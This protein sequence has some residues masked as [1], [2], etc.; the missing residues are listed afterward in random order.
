MTESRFYV[1]MIVLFIALLLWR[2]LFAGETFFW[3]TPL[4]QFVPWLRQMAS[5]WRAGHMPLWNQLVGCGAPLAANYQAAVFY[6]PHL[7]YLILP[8]EVA[9]VWLAAFHLLLAGWGMYRWGRAAGLSPFSSS[10]GALAI[11]GSGFLVS[12]V[13]LFPSIVHTFPWLP[14]WLWCAEE[15]LQHSGKRE[16]LRMGLALGMGLLAGHAQTAFYGGVLLLAYLLFRVMR[17]EGKGRAILAFALAVLLGVGL[18]AV[19]LLPT[20]ELMLLSQ[21][22]GGVRY[23]LAM[24]YSFW[25]WRLI[26]FFAPD[27]F[28]NPGRGD[29]WGYA[30]Y[31]EDAGYV[32]LLPLLLALWAVVRGS[33][34]RS[35]STFWASVAL[36][37]LT[38]ALGKNTPLFP[39][40]FRYLPTF[41]WFQAPARW[42]AVVTVALAALAALGAE[43]WPA[44]RQGR[45]FGAWAI[46]AGLAML[47]GG[48]AARLVVPGMPATFGPAVIRLGATLVAAGALLLSRRDRAWWRGAVLG[49]TVLDLLLAGRPL[50]PTVERSLYHAGSGI[51]ALLSRERGP[52]RIYWPVD[53]ANPGSD[54]DAEYRVRFGYLAF[55][56]FGPRDATY[57]G[58]MHEILLPNTAMLDGLASA[59]NFDS[60][61][62]GWYWELLARVAAHPSLLRIMGVTHVISDR[63]W[64]GG[65]EVAVHQ[66][67]VAQVKVFRLPDALGRA[68]IVPQGRYTTRDEMLALLTA[69]DFDPTAEVLLEQQASAF[70]ALPPAPRAQHAAISLQDGHN[71]VTIQVNLENPGYLVLADTW[72]PGWQATVDGKPAPLM[73]AN[74]AFRAV[75]LEAGEHTV[76]MTYRPRSVLVG[77]MLSIVALL[78]QVGYRV[79]I[80][81]VDK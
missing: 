39:L 45:R 23:D 3:G 55:D 19:Q 6:P 46:V 31:W 27:F 18:A 50:I 34:R 63:A 48:A 53:P 80:R 29:Y 17:R 44:G 77:G 28:G 72:Y 11:S 57:W 14:V 61:L 38:L 54:H 15:L 30:T 43:Q 56:D 51:A 52:V 33:A 81:Q 47:T 64:P 69:P 79:L 74:Y 78:V 65:E 20:A 75:W 4:L 24:T 68:W 37:A 21:R 10:I 35:E 7:L 2:P 41:D 60:L 70:P 16:V 59:N 32:G 13:G 25:P 1:L 49:L 62:P 26:T 67:T 36:V 22:A 12:R 40:L 9:M 73:R 66:T 42:L 71:R 58:Q 5:M 76:E 8:V